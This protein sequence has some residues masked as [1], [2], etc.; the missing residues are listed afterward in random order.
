[1]NC[2]PH[3]QALSSRRYDTIAMRLFSQRCLVVV[4]AVSGWAG[5]SYPVQA[6]GLGELWPPGRRAA[7]G[8]QGP[9]QGLHQQGP[10]SGAGVLGAGTVVAPGPAAAAPSDTAKAADDKGRQGQGQQRQRQGHQGPQEGSRPTGPDA[11]RTCRRSSRRDQTL[12]DALQSRIN[13]LTTDFVNRDDPVQRA[14][15]ERDRQKAA[16]ELDRLQKSVADEQEGPRPISTK[17]RARLASLPAGCGEPTRRA[18]PLLRFC[19]SRT[20]TRCGRCSATRSRRRATRSSKRATS[21]KPSP[22]CRAR[23]RASCC[24]TSGCRTATGSASCAP[25]R[26][27]I[28]RCRSS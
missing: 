5:F 3:V 13:A 26:S 15:I 19:W 23:V 9:G 6:Q 20:R 8:H 4:L 25:P 27:S 22:P 28:P 11:R 18:R 10:G 7:E 21:L 12:A 2:W 1:M 16:S 14:G 24:P 17:K